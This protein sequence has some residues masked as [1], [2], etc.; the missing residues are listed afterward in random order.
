MVWMGPLPINAIQTSM[1][2]GK[3]M[4][5]Q[6]RGSSNWPVPSPHKGIADGHCAFWKREQGP[7]WI[8]LSART[9]SVKF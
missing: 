7:Y 1:R 4:D 2:S 3:Q 9:P 5:V 8:R 6:K